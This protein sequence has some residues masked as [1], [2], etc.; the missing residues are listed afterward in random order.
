MPSALA[1]PTRP[2]TICANDDQPRTLTRRLI[3]CAP[4]PF[5]TIFP[6]PC[7]SPLAIPTRPPTLHSDSDTFGADAQIALRCLVCPTH[8]DVMVPVWASAAGVSA[9]PI[10]L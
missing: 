5:P 4:S 3:S 1:I 9:D 8:L 7:L 6:S 10:W 2:P